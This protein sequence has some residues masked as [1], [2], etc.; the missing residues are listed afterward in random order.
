MCDA[1]CRSRLSA[2]PTVAST[3]WPA[4]PTSLPRIANEIKRWE[5]VFKERGM[6]AE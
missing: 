3:C 2:S 4:R 6:R 1:A 5:P